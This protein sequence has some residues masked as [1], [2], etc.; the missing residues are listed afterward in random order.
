MSAN[1]SD[2]QFTSQDYTG[3]KKK[4]ET[5]RQAHTHRPTDTDKEYPDVSLSSSQTLGIHQYWQSDNE[6]QISLC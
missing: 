4:K 5:G 6:A 1:L 3:V 2:I